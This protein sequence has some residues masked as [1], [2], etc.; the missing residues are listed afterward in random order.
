MTAGKP[1][2]FGKIALEEMAAFAQTATGGEPASQTAK[3]LLF[4]LD[5]AIGVLEALRARVAGTE[6]VEPTAP[7]ASSDHSGLV[8]TLKLIVAKALSEPDLVARHYAEF[9]EAVWRALSGAGDLAAD[10]ADFRFKN[11]GWSESAFHRA[12]L[13]IY[14][15]WERSMQ[16]WLESQVLSEIDRKRVAFVF[17]QV[18]AA[19]SP[20]NLP[21][22]PAALKRAIQTEGDSAVSGLAHLI[23]GVV[24][25]KGMPR[26]VKRDAYVIGRDLGVTPG[27]V[28]FRNAQ[29]EVIQYS[30]RTPEVHERPLLLVPAQ[31]N[32]YYVFDLRPRNSLLASLV[33]SGQQPFAVSWRSPSPDHADWGLD[34][35][36]KATLEAVDAVCDITGQDSVGVISACAGGLTAMAMMGYLAA[37]ADGRV[38]HH[39]LLATCLFTGHQSD[40]ELFAT[41]Q[42]VERVRRYSAATGLMYGDELSKSFFWLRPNDLVWRYWINNCLM[43]KEPPSLDVLFW[44]NDSTELPARLHSDFIDMYL[45]DVFRTP[46]ALTVL[47]QVLDFD[48]FHLDGYFVGGEEDN[49]MPWRGCFEAYRRFRGR[50][51]FILSPSGHVQSLLRPPHIANISYYVNEADVAD[52]ERWRAGATRRDGTWWIDWQAWL[53]ARSGSKRP[54]PRDL[55]SQRYPALEPAPGRYVHE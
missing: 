25:N 50:N 48:A 54:A 18:I 20:S 24:S 26:Q 34:T 11:R 14:L 49:L 21:L 42:T 47:G 30:P 23:D 43:G 17:T 41:P 31:I 10:P 15:A 19:L 32:K 46:G 22:Q 52:A 33:G 35:Y 12:L 27:A 36:V 45:R 40:L 37:R 13:Q 51:R 2:S 55:G 8:G 4:V 9:A 5:E 38:A 3:K 7:A 44:D 16:S 28:V 1:D 29:C 6:P 53:G 39:T